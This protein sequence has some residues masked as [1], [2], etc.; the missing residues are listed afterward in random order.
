MSPA[1]GR[2]GSTSRAARR[3]PRRPSCRR[4][5]EGAGS[6]AGQVWVIAVFFFERLALLPSQEGETLRKLT[7][8]LP[9]RNGPSPSP[10]HAPD[11]AIGGLC[12]PNRRS[13]EPN[14]EL[15]S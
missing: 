5:V 8:R 12:P 13:E 10:D 3:R 15:Q 7:V 2:S 11:P 4:R 1:S 6:T 9:V 14:T